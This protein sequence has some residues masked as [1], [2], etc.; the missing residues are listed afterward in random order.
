MRH[1]KLAAK[2]LCMVLCVCMFSP[3]LHA[4]EPTEQSASSLSSSIKIVKLLWKANPKSAASTLAK[5]L[6]I[7]LGRDQQSA[8]AEA[9][10]PIQPLLEQSIA[11]END[12]RFYVSLASLAIL[13][14]T[15]KSAVNQLAD[16]I[17][18]GNTDQPDAQSLELL[19]ATWFKVDSEAAFKYLA[20]VIGGQSVVAPVVMQRA[21]TTDRSRAAEIL[22][23]R[24]SKLP[25]EQQVSL[26]EPLTAQ[27]Y[28][29]AQI[30][31]CGK[32]RRR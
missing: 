27:A 1:S 22:L 12:P 2:T 26:I 13:K 11:S 18:R 14:S 23:S 7:A 15:D 29:D 20:E 5:S 6:S 19:V 4:Q 24:W 25:R 31:Q 17:A 28:H 32:V 16:V 8:L 10:A 30:G 3:R 9:L 21:L